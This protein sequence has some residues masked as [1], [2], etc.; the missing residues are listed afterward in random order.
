MITK[1]ALFSSNHRAIAKRDVRVNFLRKHEAHATVVKSMVC[2]NK[3]PGINTVHEA[4]KSHNNK[5]E[6]PSANLLLVDVL[7]AFSCKESDR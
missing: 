2:C 5:I 7:D 3:Q 6:A 1:V 4:V